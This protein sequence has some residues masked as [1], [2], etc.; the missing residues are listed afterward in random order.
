M[1]FVLYEV[2]LPTLELLNFILHI[3]SITFMAVLFISVAPAKL[4]RFDLRF[5][6]EDCYRP[7]QLK[8]QAFRACQDEFFF[9]LCLF[10]SIGLQLC[11]LNE[12]FY[13]KKLKINILSY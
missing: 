5:L 2:L 11:D 12:L 13:F 3:H 7:A 6:C 9:E 4:R 1:L 10:L 8:S